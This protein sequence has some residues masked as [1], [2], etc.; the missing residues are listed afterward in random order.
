M[1]K[2]LF[3]VMT[4]AVLMT[5]CAASGGTGYIQYS[6]RQLLRTPVRLFILAVAMAEAFKKLLAGKLV[7]RR[8]V[9]NQ[10]ASVYAILRAWRTWSP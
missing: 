10:L 1:K 5:A 4:L 9:E 7:A 2:F 8:E 6:A 3:F